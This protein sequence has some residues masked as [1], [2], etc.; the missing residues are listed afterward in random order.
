[1]TPHCSPSFASLP[2]RRPLPPTEALAVEEIPSGD[3]WQYEPEWDGFRCLLFAMA[4][5]SNCSRRPA[6][7]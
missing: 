3:Q 5:R 2:L 4:T 1:M 7:R 6:S